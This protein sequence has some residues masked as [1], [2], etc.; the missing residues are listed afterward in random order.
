MVGRDWRFRDHPSKESI[1]AEKHVLAYDTPK[2][3]YSSLEEALNGIVPQIV[4]AGKVSP[5]GQFVC[6]TSWLI[7]VSS[8]TH[9][10]C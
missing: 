1:G 2:V 6:E 9:S 5:D 4:L 8:C 3:E 10:R 7:I